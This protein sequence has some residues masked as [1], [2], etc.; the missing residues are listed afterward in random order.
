VR[1]EGRQS[2]VPRVTGRSPKAS[3]SSRYSA[4]ASLVL[5]VSRPDSATGRPTRLLDAFVG[6]QLLQRLI[7]VSSF[8]TAER[9]KAIV[10]AVSVI[11][12]PQRAAPGSMPIAG[13]PVLKAPSPRP[14][15]R[16]CP[17]DRDHRRAPSALNRRPLPQVRGER[18]DG[19]SSI[20]R[21]IVATASDTLPSSSPLRHDST[22]A[23][24]RS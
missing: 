8:T 15:P 23:V 12:M 19:V 24:C 14:T 6:D 20:E 17:W 21:L 10:S 18:L 5:D 11:A 22:T 7:S 9:G 16:R 3:I 2:L 1:F 4:S 13:H